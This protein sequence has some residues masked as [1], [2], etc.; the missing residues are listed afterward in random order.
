MQDRHPE[1]D[2]LSE[3]GM[4]ETRALAVKRRLDACGRI[5]RGRGTAHSPST[6][7]RWR[8][9]RPSLLGSC[10]TQ[11]GGE[12]R[13]IQFHRPHPEAPFVEGKGPRKP[14]LSE[15]KGMLAGRE[16][17][18]RRPLRGLLRARAVGGLGAA[19]Q[20]QFGFRPKR[21]KN[22]NSWNTFA[23]FRLSLAL[24][25]LSEPLAECSLAWIRRPTWRRVHGVPPP[26]GRP[27]RPSRGELRPVRAGR[28]GQLPVERIRSPPS[29]RSMR[30]AE[31]ASH[32]RRGS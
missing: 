3:A 32:A 7:G 18:S 12:D 5:L 17:P 20:K 30:P 6:D 28:S 11:A 14:A 1:A 27:E 21:L 19:K 10:K 9:W 31:A 22:P 25:R 24:L 13:G 16:R 15:A 26:S 23:L 4:D 29:T 8:G 2:V